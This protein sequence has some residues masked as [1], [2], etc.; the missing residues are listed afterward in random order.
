MVGCSQS[1]PQITLPPPLATPVLHEKTSSLSEAWNLSSGFE[2]QDIDHRNP[3][4]NLNHQI[5]PQSSRFSMINIASL[6]SFFPPVTTAHVSPASKHIEPAVLRTVSHLQS[7][8]MSPPWLPYGEQPKPY[9][10]EPVHELDSLT[11]NHKP[12]SLAIYSTPNNPAE[13]DASDT[14]ERPIVR[15]Y[16]AFSSLLSELPASTASYRAYSQSDA[17]STL[18]SSSSQ[19]RPV[20]DRSRASS[21]SEFDL[22]LPSKNLPGP[23]QHRFTEQF[24][25][26]GYPAE[27]DPSTTRM[28]AEPDSWM[29]RVASPALSVVSA[30]SSISSEINVGDHCRHTPLAHPHSLRPSLPP[31]QASVSQSRRRRAL[32]EAAL[33][34]GRGS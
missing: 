11:I 15:R 21:T 22:H 18:R 29:K 14:V 4:L 20:A 25:K 30:V 17:I 6:P 28:P 10:M 7:D 1:H 12:S 19:T 24:P 23:R 3:P 13:L 2:G 8:S 31:V 16:S 27:R 32:M 33:G 5:R 34:L 9:L 26:L